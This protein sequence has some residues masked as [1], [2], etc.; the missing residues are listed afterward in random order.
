M[1][2]IGKAL[3][4]LGTAA[5]LAVAGF[6]GASAAVADDSN[7][8]TRYSITVNQPKDGHTYNAYRIFSGDLD[9]T[10]TILSNIDWGDGITEP[11]K[12]ALRAALSV[13][14]DASPR[15]VAEELA[16][17]TEDNSAAAK[18]VAAVFANS[19]NTWMVAGQAKEK[20]YVI[21]NLLPGYYA[22]TDQATDPAITG[23]DA[24]TSVILK[25][26]ANVTVKPKQETPSVTK[27]VY[28]N[29]S[30]TDS[31]DAGWRESADHTINETF[32]FRLTATVP[33]SVDRADYSS[34]QLV[35]QDSFS[36]GITFESI[37]SV[38]IKVGDGAFADYTGYASSL[39]AATKGAAKLVVTL[40][41]VLPTIGTS[42]ATV[43]VIYNAHLNEEAHV[44]VFSGG[45]TNKNEVYL[46]YS[47]NPY[48][49]SSL[50]Q[51]ETQ[52]VYV[53]TYEVWAQKVDG[54]GA[55]L[56]GAGFKLKDNATGSYL[57][58]T[59]NDTQSAYV[60]DPAGKEEITSKILAEGGKAVFNIA[61][62]DAGTYTLEES[63]TPAGYNKADDKVI[64]ITATHTK[65]ETSIASNS[66]MDVKITNIAGSKLPETGSIGTTL[67][68]AVGGL[69]VLVAAAGL[70]IAL[71]K[72]NA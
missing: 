37:A 38:K 10:G 4:A 21:K 40:E 22:V 39:N 47:N 24:Y 29:K 58:F 54:D 9:T 46:Q 26:S 8:E 27:E 49:A 28:D 33:A 44:N 25:V 45:T 72:R 56:A 62:L 55:P 71:R 17:I 34:Y 43:E 1:N 14:S 66:T 7:A 18:K 65:S 32:Q 5:A 61:G 67:L 57:K 63:T 35:F 23:D 50:G 68:T 13:A 53:Y 20:P 70:T 42:A 48:L 11:G 69:V 41:N 59:W 2:K 51:T 31:V 64:T 16:K 52:D 30:N 60:V 19:A 3:V 12:T 6:A 15:T 36:K